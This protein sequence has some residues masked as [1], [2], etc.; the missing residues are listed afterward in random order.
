MTINEVASI[1]K[2]KGQISGCK[3][4][5]RLLMHFSVVPVNLKDRDAFHVT[6]EEYLLAL[7]NVIDEL[8]SLDVQDLIASNST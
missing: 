8:V 7:I 4:K 6:I 1:L 2:G 5:I 3:K